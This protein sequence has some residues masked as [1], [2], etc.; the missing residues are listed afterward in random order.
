MANRTMHDLLVEEM[1]EILDAEKQASRAYPKLIKM[2]SS[3]SLK[4][5]FEQHNEETKGQIERL[6]QIF[7]ELDMRS[8]G[9]SC[10]A[11]RGLVEDAQDL[12]DKNFPPELLDVAL[13]A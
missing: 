3:D 7:E 9:K 12:V 11:L 4:E 2:A 8:R 13:I 10:E 1:R 5:A 6:N